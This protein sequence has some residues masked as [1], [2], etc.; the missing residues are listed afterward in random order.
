MYEVQYSYLIL[1]VLVI[2]QGVFFFNFSRNHFFTKKYF[3][4]NCELFTLFVLQ[5]IIIIRQAIFLRYYQL[6]NANKY[7]FIKI[8]L[9]LLLLLYEKR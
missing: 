9:I 4:W 8:I 5:K 3:Y 6:S 7:Y 2:Y 1:F